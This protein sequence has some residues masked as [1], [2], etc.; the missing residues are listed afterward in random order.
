MHVTMQKIIWTDRV[1]NEEVL[2]VLRRVKGD[3]LRTR[4][5]NCNVTLRRV[6]E[7][8][9]KSNI[10]YIFLRVRG[11][12]VPGREGV[13]MRVRACR[14]ATRMRHIVTALITPLAQSHFSTL[15]HKRSDFQE[16]KLL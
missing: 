6:R 2:R 9:R 16:K 3:I 12:C 15:S 14:R 8:P 11:V 5:C 7:L 4:Q 1:K 13:C 10:Y